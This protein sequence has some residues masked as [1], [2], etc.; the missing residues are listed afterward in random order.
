MIL[1]TLINLH[2]SENSQKFRYYPSAVKLYRCAGSCNTIITS[3]TKNMFQIK[4]KI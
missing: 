4:Q 3:P 2:P 1:P